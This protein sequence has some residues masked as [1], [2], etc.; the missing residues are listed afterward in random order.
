MAV[1]EWSLIRQL[2][3]KF[4]MFIN[5]ICF[6]YISS[7]DGST[8]RRR[9]RSKRSH[10]RSPDSSRRRHR[11]RDKRSEEKTRRHKERESRKEKED[12]TPAKV[13]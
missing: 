1:E 10:R 8:R 6:I 7:Y 11:Y 5:K 2:A 3:L 13:K 9:E 4:D 12:R